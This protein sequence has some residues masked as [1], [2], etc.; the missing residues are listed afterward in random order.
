[1]PEVIWVHTSTIS[2]LVLTHTH[3]IILPIDL[4]ISVYWFMLKGWGFTFTRQSQTTVRDQL[5]WRSVNLAVN[6]KQCDLSVYISLVVHISF[7]CYLF[8]LLFLVILLFF[9]L[10][11]FSLSYTV[12]T[13]SLCTFHQR[14]VPSFIRGFITFPCFENP[15]RA[16]LVRQ[17]HNGQFKT[18]AVQWFPE[19]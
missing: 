5:T 11:W 16:F 13:P 19:V 17:A 18:Y 3:T 9:G 4:L 10:F 12:N 7:V 8:V 14:V 2:T 1:M 6:H 15:L